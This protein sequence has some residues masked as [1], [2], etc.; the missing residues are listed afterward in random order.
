MGYDGNKPPKISGHPSAPIDQGSSLAGMKL[1]GGGGTPQPS[2]PKDPDRWRK[3]RN[4]LAIAALVCLLLVVIDLVVG[5]GSGAKE[6]TVIALVVAGLA[7]LMHL[8]Q[9]DRR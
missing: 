8:K 5:A 4:V 1:P 2:K 3:R 9:P 7:A 6:W